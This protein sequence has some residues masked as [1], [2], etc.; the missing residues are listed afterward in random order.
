MHY[1]N[2][3]GACIIINTLS[4]TQEAS[5]TNALNVLIGHQDCYS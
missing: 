1:I 5:L 2:K 4:I 3:Q